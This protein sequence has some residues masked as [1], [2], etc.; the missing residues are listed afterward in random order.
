MAERFTEQ[1]QLDR[2]LFVPTNQ[3]PL[4]SQQPSPRETH[5]RLQMLRIVCRTH[6]KFSLSEL[7]VRRP[8]PSYS[9]DTIRQ[10]RL[11]YPEATI[12]MMIGSD[13]AAQFRQWKDWQE[14]VQLIQLCVAR[15]PVDALSHHEEILSS[16]RA[17]GATIH[18]LDVPLIEISSSQIR[19]FCSERRSIRFLVPDK[20][21]R[22]MRKHELYRSPLEE[23]R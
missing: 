17:D 1:I 14:I 9:I 4:K 22:Y 3:S 18:S 15:R 21:G 6:P 11:D 16:L 2:C 23:S 7:E 10:L 5:H 20:V 12:Y 8:G 19:A 13:Q